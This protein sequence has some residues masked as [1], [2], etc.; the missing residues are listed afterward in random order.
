[1]T[2]SE[3]QPFVRFVRLQSDFYDGWVYPV[4]HRLFFCVSGRGSVLFDDRVCSVRAGDLLFWPSSARYRCRPEAEDPFRFLAVNFD[5][6]RRNALTDGPAIPFVGTA[7]K[8]LYRFE[9]VAFSDAAE[10]S[11]PICL[12]NVPELEGAFRKLLEEQTFRQVFFDVRSAAVLSEILI[13]VL[14]RVRTD[15]TQKGRQAV[16]EILEYVR[17]NAARPL[18][19]AEIG[20]TFGYHPNYVS[21]LLLRS[22]GLPLHQYLLQCRLQRGAE[23]LRESELP[24]AAVARSCGFTGG[25]YFGRLFLRRYGVT[26]GVYRRRYRE[27]SAGES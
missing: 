24:V 4:D 17:E 10:L 16:R 21:F 5:F 13:R 6:T 27:G 12:R 9:D 20:R 26:P 15:G 7:P 11:A 14:R 22:T 18:S 2:F 19:N 23:L 8:G 25:T 1:M 3:S